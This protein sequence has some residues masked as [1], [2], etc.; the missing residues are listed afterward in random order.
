M[1]TK[2]K[3]ALRQVWSFQHALADLLAR[4]TLHRSRRSLTRLDD[5]LLQDIGLTRAE[6]EAEAARPLWDAPA[7]W[8]HD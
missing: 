5:R 4:G 2:A 7:H 3:S 6:A 8:R 1:S